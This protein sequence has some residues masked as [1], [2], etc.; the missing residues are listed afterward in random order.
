MAQKYQLT[1]KQQYAIHYL[2]D[3]T[4]KMVLFGGSAGGQ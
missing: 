2:N 4:T 3:K 1:L